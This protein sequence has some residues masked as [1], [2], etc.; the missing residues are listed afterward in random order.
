MISNY[1]TIRFLVS[2]TIKK[3]ILQSTPDIGVTIV[4]VKSST[5]IISDESIIFADV[6]FR[7]G[8]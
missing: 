4:S 1:H 8:N 7:V 6:E 2:K 3:Q 5:K